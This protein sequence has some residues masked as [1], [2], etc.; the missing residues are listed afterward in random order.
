MLSVRLC[1]ELIHNQVLWQLYQSGDVMCVSHTLKA[2]RS[3]FWLM[4][5]LIK[6]E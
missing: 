1:G 6:D 3:N 5:P 2:D 4:F